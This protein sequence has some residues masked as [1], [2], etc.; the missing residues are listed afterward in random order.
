[1]NALAKKECA[2]CNGESTKL[3]GKALAKLR[4]ELGGQWQ[5]AKGHQ[6]EKEYKFP[7][8]VKAL[9]FT[10]KVGK[11]AEEQGHH[12]DIYLTWGKVKLSIWTHSVDGLT[13]NDF[14]LAAKS[15]KA[16]NK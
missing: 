2:A 16:F 5:V 12:P 4:R 13:E 8:F 7:N 3:S 15:D 1:M 14:V 9:A 6:L 10:N 11:I